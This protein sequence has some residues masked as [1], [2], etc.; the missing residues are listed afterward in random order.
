MRDGVRIAIELCL[1]QPIPAGGLTAAI[2]C[3][4]YWRRSVGAPELIAKMQEDEL[5]RAEAVGFALVLVDARGSGASFGTW[6]QPW[7]RAEIEDYGEVVDWIVGQ[8]WSN[9]SVV[10]Y[11][12]S[13]DGTAAHLLAATGRSAV[14]AVAPRFS[15]YDAYAHIGFPGGVALDWFLRMWD[16]GNHAMDGR[17]LPEGVTAMPLLG[18]VK[19]V[20][21][22]EDGRLLVTA[23]HDHSGNFGLWEAVLRAEF[24]GDVA[25]AD[26]VLADEVTPMGRVADIEAAGVP[27]YV[28][29]SWFD[30]GYA[31]SAIAGMQ[32]QSNVQR[33]VI[34]P[35]AHGAVFGGMGRPVRPEQAPLD[36]G[37]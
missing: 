13:Y 3:T 17:P 31:A 28:W 18:A 5:R 35:W 2:R 34:G 24:R 23:R 6:A 4:R 32:R 7:S 29:T 25:C 15:T 10:G 27:L 20:D 14:K 33:V 22:D 36:P 8:P 37:L 9:G 26:G 21:D 30:G 16:A 12:T 11:G 1:P 19:P